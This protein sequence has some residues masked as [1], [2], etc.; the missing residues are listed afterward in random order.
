VSPRM[1]LA[2]LLVGLVFG[3]TLS[4]TG[5]S[6]PDVIRGALLF[7][8]AYLYLF[9]ASAVLVATVGVHLLRRSRARALLTGERVDWRPEAPQRRHVAGSVL[10]GSGWALAD[11]CPGPIATQVGQGSP[12]ASSRSRASWPEFGCFCGVNRPR[13]TP[14]PS[15]ICRTNSCAPRI[16]TRVPSGGR[17]TIHTPQNQVTGPG[18]PAEPRGEF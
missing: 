13:S 9:F 1:R 10:F 6:D 8:E 5:M 12:G 14:R 3:V 11:A 4:W 18:E 17:R 15:T 16:I 7:H 2:G